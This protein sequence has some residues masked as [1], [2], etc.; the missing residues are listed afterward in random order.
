MAGAFGAITTQRLEKLL[1]IV[2][3]GVVSK[4]GRRPLSPVHHLSSD[5][6]PCWLGYSWDYTT[7]FW[8]I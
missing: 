5:Q 3:A 8:G 7:Q 1:S 2:V 6:N 4:D